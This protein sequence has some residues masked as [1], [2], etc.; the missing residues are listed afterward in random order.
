MDME[1]KEMTKIKTVGDF[2]KFIKEFDDYR[3]FLD[4]LLNDGKI[5]DHG[6]YL[7]LKNRMDFLMK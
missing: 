7:L 1:E 5:N 3:E 6:Y 2:E 4:E